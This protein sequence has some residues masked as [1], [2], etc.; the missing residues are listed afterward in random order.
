MAGVNFPKSFKGDFRIGVSR[1]V[2]C[3]LC[4]ITCQWRTRNT[5]PLACAAFLHE[6]AKR[7]LYLFLGYFNFI[8]F[9]FGRIM[10]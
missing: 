9:V 3:S 8:T 10:L 7:E 1:Q 2:E 5:E 6:I 4:V